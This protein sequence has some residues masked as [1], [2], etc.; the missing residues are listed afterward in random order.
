MLP[1]CRK[2]ALHREYG[3]VH[4]RGQKQTGARLS[5]KRYERI[6]QK[7]LDQKIH[8]LITTGLS[9]IEA[10]SIA[11]Q[12]NSA[13]QALFETIGIAKSDLLQAGF[14][15]NPHLETIFKIPKKGKQA[16]IEANITFTVS[17]L[18]QIPLRK[19]V[20]E[21]ELE[22]SSLE[23]LHAILETATQAKIAY[24]DC[25]YH[26]AL[27]QTTADILEKIQ[28]LH[29]RIYYRYQFGYSS[30]LDKHFADVKLGEWQTIVIDAKKA[31]R[32]S[33]INVYHAL[34]L[35]ISTQPIKLTDQLPVKYEKLMPK[36]E[37]VSF[38]FA[39]R[40]EMQIAHL[41]IQQAKHTIS[42][43]RS[44]IVDDVTLGI[45][46]EREFEKTGKGAGPLFGISIP[47]FDTNFGNIERARYRL[48]QAHQELLT[49]KQNV[50]QEV[51]L[52]YESLQGAIEKIE[53]YHNT[54][55][56][57]SQKAIA[58]AQEYVDTMQLNMLVI[59][60]A[61]L[62]LYNTQKQALDLYHEA[63]H[64]FTML[65]KALGSTVEQA[66]KN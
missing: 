8:Q 43:E 46:Y 41:N 20:A 56:P 58:Y 1:S 24:D 7:V 66:R 45:S 21:D 5:W 23:V 9:R 64:A 19:Q 62:T 63:T 28:Q 11:L 27:L 59:I 15:T 65:E 39:Y 36:E 12:N 47:I 54:I 53:I 18:W 40:P 37:L 60:D 4:H 48:H 44:R 3:K 16:K 31:L 32:Q 55:T 35:P 22:I 17:D 57:A 14:F 49:K 29:D 30:D 51:H 13:L 52:A 2:I 34:G 61:Q 26:Q 25:L 33:Y 38:A 10:I 50:S 6:Q 42:L